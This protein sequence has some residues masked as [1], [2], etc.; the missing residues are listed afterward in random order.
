MR[1]LH[2]QDDNGGG[3][4]PVET[5]IGLGG[6]GFQWGEK[7]PVGMVEINGKLAGAVAAQLVAA[8]AGQKA[9]L[10]QGLGAAVAV[11]AA[12]QLGVVDLFGKLLIGKLYVHILSLQ[13]IVNGKG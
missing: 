1:I 7:Q 9:H 12:Q 5:T 3:L 11:A 4:R 13:W 8:G 10:G 2:T 6:S